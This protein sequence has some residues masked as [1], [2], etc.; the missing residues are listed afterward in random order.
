MAI[1]QKSSNSVNGASTISPALTGV[2]SGNTLVLLIS[3]VSQADN[4]PTDSAGQTWT[5]GF[6]L[7]NAGCEVACYYLL[8]ANAGTHTLTVTAGGATFIT[9]SIVEIPHCSAVDV[10]STVG[11]AL[12]TATTI[13]TPSITTTNATDALF[14]IM[15]ADTATG[16]TNANITD[17]PS[18]WTSVF[19]QQ[20]TSANAGGQFSYKEI[21]S[22][23]SQSVT[24]TF[25]A[26]TSG[27]QYAAAMISFMQAPAGVAF[28]G[29]GS[30]ATTGSG[31]FKP[32]PAFAAASTTRAIGSAGLSVS[33]SM[34][35]AGSASAAGS[36][37][38]TVR[39]ALAAAGLTSASGSGIFGAAPVVTL[40]QYW[41]KNWQT[42]TTAA[43]L[44][45]GSNPM[46]VAAGSTL[47]A[48][49]AGWDSSQIAAPVISAGSF[50]TPTNG[51][52]FNGANITLGIAYQQNATGGSVTTTA[53]NVAIGN[54][55]EIGVWIYEVANMP[56]TA[57]VR[58]C[59]GTHVV[60]SSQSWSQSSDAS[61]VVG[62]LAFAVT[63]YE[64]SAGSV[65]AGL[66][67]PPSG[68]TSRGVNQDATNFI[69]TEIC[70]KIVS[71]AGTQTASW[72]NTDANT[73]EHLSVML[74]LQTTS[75]T[76]VAFTGAGVASAAGSA[77]LTVKDAFSG[78]SVATATAA[79]ALTVRVPFVGAGTSNAT[80]SA[81]LTTRDA[82]AGAGATSATGA[83]PLTVQAALSGVAVASAAGL[84]TLTGGSAGANFVGAGSTGTAGAAALTV[85]DAFTGA[86]TA[87][88][89]GSGALTTAVALSGAGSATSAGAGS[90][91]Q[92]A[93]LIAAG[94][95]GSQGSG[96]L[97]TSAALAGGGFS[98]ATA[99]GTLSIGAG[100]VAF[101]GNGAAT[102]SAS[103]ALTV[104]PRFAGAG[105]T[106]TTGSGAFAVASAFVPGN[107]S[108]WLVPARNTVAA[109]P[110]RV[111]VAQATTD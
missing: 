108:V 45:S 27:S 12:N 67:D 48:V 22:T 104:R 86:G 103:A 35:G 41:L 68:W 106:A 8:S 9:Y 46:T 3:A 110:H 109:E 83:A 77:A 93:I 111:T 25:N 55:G 73:T 97:T 94:S 4:L 54:S 91:T 71:G 72:S 90:L 92:G 102:T 85:R 31:A 107:E 28:V 17:P 95:S 2:T 57:V 66:T 70:S 100:G 78:S 62:D 101:A 89:A 80:G 99:A 7:T 96:S 44:Q 69:P 33:G 34:S 51:A 75:Q 63:T 49:W 6:Y 81:A 76:S 11:T 14:G 98:I 26:D 74:T 23:G 16:S 20:N 52:Q 38:L 82:L 87:S 13:S 88:T 47:I 65:S 42:G 105:V 56:A 10:V 40:K 24:W 19:A 18:G 21:S 30:T 79:G 61:P 15:V 84:A 37:S 64:N 59:A 58:N 53:P 50:T 36:G 1:V 43:T 5:K 32:V 29:A 60:S 39:A